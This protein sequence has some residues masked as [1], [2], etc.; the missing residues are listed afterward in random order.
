M[1]LHYDAARKSNR[2]AINRIAGAMLRAAAR[3]FRAAFKK[4]VRVSGM[5]REL[6]AV[7]QTA[8]LTDAEL[9]KVN[10]LLRDLIEVFGSARKT[11]E[12]GKLYTVTF[13]LTP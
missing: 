1:T 6:W 4:G 7:Q 5:R 10:R 9:I 11:E 13:V 12:G 8:R 3:A 2:D